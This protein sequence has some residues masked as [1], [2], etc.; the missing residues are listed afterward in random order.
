MVGYLS[1]HQPQGLSADDRAQSVSREKATVAQ[2]SDHTC[3]SCGSLWSERDLARTG[4]R[5]SECN[6]ELA[7]TARANGGTN[8]GAPEPMN[9]LYQHGDIVLDRYRIEKLLGKGGFAAT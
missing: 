8:G 9:W 1:R 6:L 2:S 3:P 5:C 7:H 4:Y